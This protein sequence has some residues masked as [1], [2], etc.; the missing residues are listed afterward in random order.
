[1]PGLYKKHTPAQPIMSRLLLQ[2]GNP[3]PP[4]DPGSSA[5]PL[6]E[7][8]GLFDILTVGKQELP[9]VILTSIA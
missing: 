2:S 1:M 5:C 9:S 6:H 7:H 8:G 4:M 3:D